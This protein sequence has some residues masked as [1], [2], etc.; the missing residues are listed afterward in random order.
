MRPIGRV[1]NKAV[2]RREKLNYQKEFKSPA[3]FFTRK[4]YI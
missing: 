3:T 1:V 2:K 4:G